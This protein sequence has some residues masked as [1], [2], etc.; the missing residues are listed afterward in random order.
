MK[1]RI[2]RNVAI[3]VLIALTGYGIGACRQNVMLN[4]S[5]DDLLVLNDCVVSA[6]NYLAAIK[7]QHTLE[8][9]FWAKILLVRYVNHPADHAYCVW[10]KD[11]TVY[12]Y[13]RNA[14]DGFLIP[15]YTRDARSIAIVLAQ[16]LSK[17]LHENLS[18]SQA[19]FVE[20]WS[21]VQ[22]F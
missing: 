18:V 14:G 8:K 6:C 5:E 2:A 16:E 10:E 9:N 3:Y 20:R 17:H 4:P 12:A 19:D 15:V 21:K 13:Y 7:A 22:R 1:T 11:G